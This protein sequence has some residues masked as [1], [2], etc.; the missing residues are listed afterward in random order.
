LQRTYLAS[1]LTLKT[2]QHKGLD[3]I[4]V[5]GSFNRE[6]H[7]IIQG[8]QGRHYSKTHGCYC[9]PNTAVM[10]KTL[11][12][13]LGHLIQEQIIDQ[14]LREFELGSNTSRLLPPVPEGYEALLQRMRYSDATIKNYTGQF[15]QFL[16]FISPLTL[17]QISREDIHRYL[18]YLVNDRKVSA[19]TQNI[20]INAI[21]FYLEHMKKLS[22]ETYI[23][24]R[25]RKSF[26]LPVVLSE[27]ETKNIFSE[28]PNLKHRCLLLIIYSSGLRVSE[29]LH[30]KWSH[31]DVQRKVIHVRSGK[32][33]KDR[34]TVLSRL[35]QQVLVAYKSQY[36]TTEWVFEGP[37][38]K[39]YTTSSVNKIIK[40]S[41][42]RAGIEKCIS[43]HTLRH[44]FA[45]H[46]L[47]QGT[48]LRYIQALLG[49]ESSRTTE[50][51][52]HVTR[53]GFDQLQS[54]LDRIMENRILED[55]TG[56]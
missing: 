11:T 19:S 5:T 44:S 10:A 47:E 37:N 24:E 46:L 53:K 38:G 49:H 32:G 6:T 41:V 8:I 45:T 28:T 23:I 2:I 13:K 21:K 27:D 16:S 18:L 17:D 3:W 48:D 31:I 56:I 20:A 36:Q 35:A 14:P 55:K 54:P 40:R 52:A 26:R 33:D 29:A 51:Y 43:A 39:P 34:I 1:M 50:R 30:L 15:R 9:F 25:P 42:S 4:A 22:R 12:E 7:Y